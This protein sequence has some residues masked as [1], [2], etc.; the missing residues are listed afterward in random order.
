[1]NEELQVALSELIA[2]T[3]N[4]I[5]SAT[6]FL[7]REIPE[8]IQ[9]L[10]LWHG[11]YSLVCFLL[12]VVLLSSLPFQIK[13]VL[14]FIPEK[15]KKGD[16]CNWYWVNENKNYSSLG[17]LVGK[18]DTAIAFN[19]CM[20]VFF[21]AEFFFCLGLVNMKWLQIYIAPKVW[22]IE[23]ASKLAG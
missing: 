4:G 23:Y 12:G 13:R 8:V 14:S 15:I 19:N 18:S 17:F 3:S 1:M 6:D 2:N 21:V 10:I 7:S 22:L 16:E 9:Q 11:I 5:N 20:V